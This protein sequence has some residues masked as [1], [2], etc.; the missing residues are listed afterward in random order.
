MCYVQ[1]M[2]SLCRYY[3]ALFSVW[4]SWF[5][6][7]LPGKSLQQAKLLFRVWLLAVRL[8]VTQS[9]L[10]ITWGFVSARLTQLS[11]NFSSFLGFGCQPDISLLVITSGLYLR[12]FIRLL[13]MPTDCIRRA[14][15]K[16]RTLCVTLYETF[17]IHSNYFGCNVFLWL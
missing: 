17:Q 4:V 11:T 15:R 1:P 9:G 5:R 6:L 16:A 14:E 13:S 12:L 10:H 8:R 7:T 3:F 2:T